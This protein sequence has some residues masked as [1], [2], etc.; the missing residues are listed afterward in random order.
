[1]AEGATR[2]LHLEDFEVGQSFQ[3]Q[4]M[5]IDAEAIKAFGALFDPQ[6]FHLDERAAQGT[7]FGGLAASGW[8]TAALTM[9]M[10]VEGAAPVA[11]GVIGAGVELTWPSPV[12]PGDTLRVVS[13]VTAIRPSQSKPDRGIVTLRSETLNQRGEP[14]QVMSSRLLVFRRS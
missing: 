11:G 14:V 3:S 2:R 8:H 1:M 6:P 7:F 13:K 9:R 12:R 4:E 10:L 5:S